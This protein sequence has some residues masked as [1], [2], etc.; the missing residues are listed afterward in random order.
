MR[1]CVCYFC[2][3][4]WTLD[5]YLFCATS[6]FHF[7]SKATHSVIYFFSISCKV[8][9]LAILCFFSYLSLLYSCF[10]TFQ[11]KRE[12][13][14]L[15]TISRKRTTTWNALR[16]HHFGGAKDVTSQWSSRNSRLQT[17][18]EGMQIWNMTSGRCTVTRPAKRL[19]PHGPCQLQS[20][21]NVIWTWSGT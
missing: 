11:K 4:F 20:Q 5:N 14:L 9:F 19:L 8:S 16:V 6:D 1:C 2:N 3:N 18:K 15:L 17:S 13:H 12:L 21:H 10:I 7:K